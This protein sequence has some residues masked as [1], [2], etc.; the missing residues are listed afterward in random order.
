MSSELKRVA[1][2]SVQDSCSF[3]ITCDPKYSSGSTVFFVKF[4]SGTCFNFNLVH[5]SIRE[6][7]IF[8]ATWAKVAYHHVE[9]AHTV[10]ALPQ[11][12]I[13]WMRCRLW[14]P[15]CVFKD[16]G[17]AS[18]DAVRALAEFAEVFSWCIA[19]TLSKHTGRGLTLSRDE[20]SGL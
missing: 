9:T 7:A 8:T 16:A 18:V 20:L 10:C 5:E 14:P 4:L 13:G 11:G 1:F 6:H 17:Y 19:A 15:G 3:F 2:V 12:R